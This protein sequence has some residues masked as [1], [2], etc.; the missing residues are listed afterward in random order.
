[1][2]EDHGSPKGD[3]LADFEDAL[4]EQRPNCMSGSG[5]TALRENRYQSHIQ[6]RL[7]ELEGY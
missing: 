4:F 1:M 3:L 5:L 2:Q 6:H 7:T